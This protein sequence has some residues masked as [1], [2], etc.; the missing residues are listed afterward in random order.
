MKRSILLLTTLLSAC[1]VRHIGEYVPK[2]R[3]YEPPAATS[4]ATATPAA[5]G[6]L[7]RDDRPAAK[8]FADARALHENDLV[9]V[10]VEENADARRSSD[11]DLQRASDNSASISAFLGSMTAAQSAELSAAATNNFRGAGSTARSEKLSATVPALVR[12]VLPNGNLFIEGHRVVLVNNEEAHFYVS[13]VVRPFD[14]D[15]ENSVKSS[16]IADA[17]IEFTGRGS[18]TDTNQQGIVQRYFGW[19]WPF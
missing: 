19:I 7:W 13:G 10:K 11:V 15:Q 17:Q 1:S 2:Q 12:K 14:I 3:N 5:E 8:L 6:S 9:V 18:L 4:T 16:M